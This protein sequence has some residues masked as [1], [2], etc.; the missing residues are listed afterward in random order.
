MHPI[1]FRPYNLNNLEWLEIDLEKEIIEISGEKMKT[2]KDFVIPMSK[3]IKN[4]LLEIKQ[5]SYH[6]S[7]YV[8]PSPTSP[9][10][11]ISENTLN[12]C[13]KRLGYLNKHVPHSFRSTFSTIAQE[14][15]KEHGHHSDVIEFCLAHEQR[16]RVKAAYSR[17]NKMRY[18]E[19]RK[20]LMQFWADW[21]DSLG[22]EDI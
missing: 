10:K 1:F 6:R 2:K 16:N 21:L 7:K 20:E 12:M 4:I 18:F 19:E 9:K 13:L 15:R 3:Q 22:G 8:F 11:P 17:D 5:Y 14:K